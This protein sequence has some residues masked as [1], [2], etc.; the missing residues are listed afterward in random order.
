MV[1]RCTRSLGLKTFVIT[2]DVE[3]RVTSMNAV[4]ESL[5]GWTQPDAANQPLDAVFRIVNGETR[6]PV[7]N[8]RPRPY[9]RASSLG[10]RI[11][12]C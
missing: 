5:T 2:T 4:A 7:E 8:R 10:W 3:G 12:P 11:T 6:Q 9:G 1:P